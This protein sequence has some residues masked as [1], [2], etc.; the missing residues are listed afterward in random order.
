MQVV[1]PNITRE[2]WDSGKRSDID[3]A[4]DQIRGWVFNQADALSPDQHA[5]PAILTLITPYL[6]VIACYHLGKDSDRQS[7]PFLR[8]GLRLVFP[9]VSTNARE[10]YITEV[11]QGLLHESIFRKVGIHHN[12][13]GYPN[14]DLVNGL[15]W[16]N[17]WWLLQEVK[18]HFNRYVSVLRAGSDAHLT[19]MF[20]AFM[21]I[22]K[23]R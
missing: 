21:K 3:V 16:L 7:T 15:L 11:R 9:G 13:P 4:E 5:G 22:R 20:D 17:P 18:E 23:S 1:S 10:Q 6:E 8:K 2:D 19:A 12:A 14:F